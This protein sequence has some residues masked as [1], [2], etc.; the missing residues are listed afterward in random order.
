[1]QLNFGKV[2]LVYV[3]M[4]LHA[5]RRNGIFLNDLMRHIEKSVHA[6][7]KLVGQY[8]G[9]IS[10]ATLFNYFSDLRSVLG[11]IEQSRDLYDLSHYFCKT[12]PRIADK[13]YKNSTKLSLTLLLHFCMIINI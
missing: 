9:S 11:E 7:G 1:M 6:H 2:N 5:E 8:P 3:L 12:F 4:I 13:F 10:R